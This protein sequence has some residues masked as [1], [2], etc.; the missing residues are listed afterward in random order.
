MS[1]E[2]KEDS[3]TIVPFYQNGDYFF[4]RGLQAFHKKHLNRAAKLLERAVK[5]TASEPIFKIQLAA[6]LSELGEYGR[7]NELL[8]SVLASSGSQQPVCH[9]FI[10]NNEVYMG[11]FYQ[12]EKHVRLY[13]E[14]E[15]NGQ[16]A[17]EAHELLELFE[18]DPF[19]EEEASS[20][21][22][23]DDHEQAWLFLR[24]GQAELAVPLLESIVSKH[25]RL[26]AAQ[27]HL[28]EALFCIGETERAFAICQE[29]LDKDSGNLLALCNLALFYFEM[30]YT[31]EAKWYRERLASVYPLDSGHAAR[32]VQVL[33]ALGNYKEVLS[34]PFP[35]DADEEAALLRCYG[36]ASYH[37]HNEKAA[38]EHLK[39]AVDL[40]DGASKQLMEAVANKQ[41]D[42]ISF[43]L[44]AERGFLS[45]TLDS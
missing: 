18:D 25:P 23:L 38:L 34:R 26:W 11:H 10:A 42:D 2:S 16:F 17:E 6:V 15:P 44:F 14:K 5:L 8:Q 4:H 12:A 1:D 32:L 19:M 39:K 13:L 37:E 9:F 41:S 30:G 43:T 31:K 33:C 27:N 28:A 20:E 36:V 40:G 22:F 35:I 45:R 21:Q 29:V 24:K 3:R 7:S